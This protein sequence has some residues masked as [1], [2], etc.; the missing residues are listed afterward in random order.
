MNERARGLGVPA[1]ETDG[2]DVTQVWEAAGQAIA[3]ARAGKGP[4][5][6]RATC[7]HLEGHFLGYQPLRVTRDPLREMPRIA[8]PL[9][10]ALIHPG[11][12]PLRERLDGMGLVN[13]AIT[14]TLRDP[15]RQRSNDPLA[16]TRDRLH[17]D[18]ARLQGLE[19]AARQE[20]DALLAAIR[21]GGAA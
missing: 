21:Q 17:T 9:V 3:R 14:A 5:F 10:R 2:R 12:A 6:L 15:R 19:A 18:P 20:I 1:V 13:G 8:G 4:T 11:G 7:V 16:R